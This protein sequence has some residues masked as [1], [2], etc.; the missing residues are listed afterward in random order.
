MSSQ[1][2]SIL[3]IFWGTCFQTPVNVAVLSTP[4]CPLQ[5]QPH[6]YQTFTVIFKRKSTSSM[7]QDMVP[8]S[9]TLTTVAV[10]VTSQCLACLC[11]P[12]LPTL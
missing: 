2:T 4:T 3:E 7:A 1:G 8:H 11:L 10:T 5:H 6:A 12:H 9:P